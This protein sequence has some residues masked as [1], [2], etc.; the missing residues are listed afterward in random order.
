MP[1]VMINSILSEKSE[2]SNSEIIILC[3]TSIL[4]GMVLSDLIAVIR[5]RRNGKVAR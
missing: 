2:V 4:I 1:F 3:L 5:S